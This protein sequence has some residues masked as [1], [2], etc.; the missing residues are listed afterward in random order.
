MHTETDERFDYEGGRQTQ[1]TIRHYE[2]Y[3]ELVGERTEYI[4]EQGQ[5]ISAQE[6]PI[7]PMRPESV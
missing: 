2:N 3:N 7:Q 1:K 4:D 5:I 6:I